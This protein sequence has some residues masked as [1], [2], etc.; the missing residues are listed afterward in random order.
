MRRSPLRSPPRVRGKVPVCC[1]EHRKVRITP[2]YAGKR[3]RRWASGSQDRDHPRV[4][5]EKSANPKV[6]DTMEGAS[7]RM[8]GKVFFFTG[9]S[10]Y[11]IFF[12]EPSGNLLLEPSGSSWVPPDGSIFVFAIGSPPRVRGKVKVQSTLRLERRDHPRV[13]GEKGRKMKQQF[14]GLGSPPRVRGKAVLRVAL[15]IGVGITPAC[16]GKSEKQ[17]PFL[18]PYQDHPR[19]CGEKVKNGFD[20]V[21]QK[22]SP[23]RMRGKGSGTGGFQSLQGITPAYSGKRDRPRSGPGTTRDHPRV[24]GEKVRCL[25]FLGSL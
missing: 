18:P 20:G 8:R 15:C 14:I 17:V 7:P 6:R 12:L 5:G 19:V 16:A 13:C 11:A 10:F 24:C 21:Y 9:A 25:S 23:P 22:G 2:A 4:C 3:R 1:P